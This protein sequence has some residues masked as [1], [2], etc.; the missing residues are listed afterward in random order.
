MGEANQELRQMNKALALK[1]RALELD[2]NFW[3]V[4]FFWV[5]VASAY[6]VPWLYGLVT[7]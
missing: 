1:N 2:R 5:G 7:T 6:V 4:T 3:V